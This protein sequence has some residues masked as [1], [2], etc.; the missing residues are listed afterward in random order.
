M[1]EALLQHRHK[2][3]P[4]SSGY[5]KASISCMSKKTSLALN[6]SALFEQA[7]TNQPQYAITDDLMP[8]T[9]GNPNAETTI[10][11]VG[12]PFC[13]PCGNAH[14][15]I[16]DW[17]KTTNG[18]QVKVIFANSN[19]D[20]DLRT[21]MTR[22]ITALSF[23]EDKLIVERALSDWYKQSMKKYDSWAEKYPVVF[24]Q[25]LDDVLERQ[26]EWCEMADISFTPT[27]FINGY[28]LLDPYQIEDLKY[29]IG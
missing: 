15:L 29:L 7:L 12:S 27:I 11:L 20:S 1:A 28:K 4:G 23:L 9:Y 10:T 22:H 8:I 17:L 26:K 16:E 19:Q 6:N 24:K 2:S 5:Q 21:K 14:K 25:D 18:V 13:E 3:V